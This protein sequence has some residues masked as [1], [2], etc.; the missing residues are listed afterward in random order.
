MRIKL[1]VLI[2]GNGNSIWILN[3]IKHV[4]IPNNILIFL[5]TPRNINKEYLEFYNSNNVL[6][7]YNRIDNSF[8]QKIPKVRGIL[9]ILYN[10]YQI[11]KY[12]PYDAIHVHF[13]DISSC[14]IAY[15]CHKLTRKEI[16]SFWG[17]DLFRSSDRQIKK[18]KAYLDKC[19]AITI[20]TE[21]MY[22][23]IMA[24]FSHIYDNKIKTIR[25]GIEAFDMIENIENL[26]DQKTS[27]ATLGLPTEKIILTIGYSASPN[28]QHLLII[29]QLARINPEILDRVF[30]VIQMTYGNSDTHY[31][32]EVRKKIK[33]ITDNFIIFDSIMQGEDIARLRVSTDIFIHGQ[34]TDALSA[35][36]QEYIYAGAI[37]LNGK[38]LKYK[39]LEERGIKYIE[40]EFFDEI[41]SLLTNIISNLQN[42]R[43]SFFNNRNILRQFSSV[44]A[45]SKEWYN[46]YVS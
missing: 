4:L 14:C 35:S 21:K 5:C 19:N 16:C 9:N 37:V 34:T 1:R 45:V 6:L 30:I 31:Q 43:L 25:F 24:V 36:F 8:I 2:I 11:Y 38:W 42:Y 41:P 46:L 28:Q 27:R 20:A 15:L 12:K 22:Y 29:E 13:A 3:Y 18:L 40:Y 7:L 33:S 44:Q 32:E 10:L 39:E 23:R 17:S 26:E